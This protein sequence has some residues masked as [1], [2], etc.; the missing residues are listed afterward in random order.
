MPVDYVKEGIMMSSES[1]VVI[2]NNLTAYALAYNLLSSFPESNVVVIESPQTKKQ[3]EYYTTLPSI[4]LPQFNLSDPQIISKLTT[5]I[6]QELHELES[7]SRILEFR[8]DPVA[9]LFRGL[10]SET[11]YKRYTTILRQS[12]IKHAVLSASEI[13]D[14]YPFISNSHVKIVELYDTLKVDLNNVLESYQKLFEELG[15]KRKVIHDTEKSLYYG[16][17]ELSHKVNNVF[18][19]NEADTFSKLEELITITLPKIQNCPY[20]TLID[21]IS[22]INIAMDME[23]YFHIWKCKKQEQIDNVINQLNKMIS[24]MLGID[25]DDL[26]ATL[27]S[28]EVLV[29]PQ[30][31]I[32][33]TIEGYFKLSFPPYMEISLVPIFTKIFSEK[34]TKI[35]KMQ[36]LSVK[37]I[38]A[39]G[40]ET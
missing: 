28:I 14:S 27:K 26:S 2:G 34:L 18:I 31:Y 10:G 12:K 22:D 16:L 19:C 8:R 5:G 20:I 32:T 1:F 33:R 38:L 11:R 3:L 4:L 23:G 13:F 40:V 17:E 25:I 29:R 15:G 21:V 9:Y 37:S 30:R 35:E 39:Q 24:S 7:L 36:N 6:I